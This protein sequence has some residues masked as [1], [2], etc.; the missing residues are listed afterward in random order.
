MTI[1]KGRLGIKLMKQVGNLPQIERYAAWTNL[2]SCT[3]LKN[4]QDACSTRK[5]TLCGTG[6][7]PVHKKLIENGT[8]S[9]INQ[10]FMNS[11]NHAMF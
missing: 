7:L 10:A 11:L 9:Q 8:T 1:C 2:I 6:I 3:L 5:S 4:R